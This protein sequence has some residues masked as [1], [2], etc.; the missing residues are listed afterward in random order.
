MRAPT[1]PPIG[2]KTKM[3]L[4][5]RRTRGA[6]RGGGGSAAGRGEGEGG[7]RGHD[8]PVQRLPPARRRGEPAL[9]QPPVEAMARLGVVITEDYE[10]RDRTDPRADQ[11]VA[12]AVP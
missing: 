2:A 9:Q 1:S 3:P 12:P 6:R 10:A 7:G 5:T 11:A 4:L 8:A